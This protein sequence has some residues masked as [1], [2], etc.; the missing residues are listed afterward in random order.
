MSTHPTTP[1][2][3]CSGTRR[4]VF[5]VSLI[6]LVC[7]VALI[8]PLYNLIEPRL[9]GIPFFYWFQFVWVIL[10]GIVTALAYKAGT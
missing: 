6:L 8:A 3:P 4:R 5:W 1:H 2:K 10:S 7:A 9:F